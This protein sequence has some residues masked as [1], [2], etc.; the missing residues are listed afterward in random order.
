M[1]L[2]INILL[3]A[4]IWVFILDLSGIIDEM[5]NGLAKWLNVKK[6]HIP[7]PFSCSL[8]MTWWTGL[9]YLLVLNRCTL[10]GVAILA[11]ACFCTPVIMNALALFR[12][13]LDKVLECFAKLLK[14]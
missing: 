1:E 2:V 12:E 9:I 5:E 4:V 8:C 11:I 3:I 13:L 14:L 10:G 7:K 6:V